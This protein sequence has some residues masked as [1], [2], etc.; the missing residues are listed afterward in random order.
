M[1]A[2]DKKKDFDCIEMKNSIQAK[3]YAETKDMTFTELRAY[4]D[5]HL[6]GDAFWE[7]INRNRKTKQE[8]G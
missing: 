2:I 3:I 7:K 8:N 1:E 5:A 4:L 6:Q